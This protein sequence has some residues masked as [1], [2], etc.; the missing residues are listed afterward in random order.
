[1]QNIETVQHGME[2]LQYKRKLVRCLYLESLRLNAYNFGGRRK[3]LLV[4]RILGV[5]FCCLPRLRTFCFTR[6]T[7]EGHLFEDHGDNRVSGFSQ[8]FPQ[9]WIALLS[10]AGALQDDAVGLD[11]K[12]LDVTTSCSLRI[13]T[14]G[15]VVNKSRTRLV[16][17][18]VH[19]GGF[20]WRMEL[21]SFHKL[22][23]GC[24]R[25]SHCRLLLAKINSRMGKQNNVK[26]KRLNK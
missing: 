9:I 2:N 14:S 3:F 5:T 10:S 1:M 6:H 22:S 16:Q 19:A 23:K 8:S 25:D 24:V 13:F 15:S 26:Q 7:E 21:L 20:L 18:P 17:V 12:I 4:H 11:E